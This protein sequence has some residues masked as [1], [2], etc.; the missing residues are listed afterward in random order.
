[1]TR[2]RRNPHP[3]WPVG[4]S[5]YYQHIPHGQAIPP[6]ADMPDHALDH[7]AAHAMTVRR[8]G[9]EDLPGVDEVWGE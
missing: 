3:D 2:T 7:H 6:D 5:R 4:T 8:R 1:M 9:M